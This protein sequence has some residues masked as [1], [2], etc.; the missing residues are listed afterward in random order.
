VRRVEAE[1]P[2]HASKHEENEIK[3][4]MT[5]TWEYDGRIERQVSTDLIIV[6]TGVEHNLS[7]A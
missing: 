3:T 5:K 1:R 7:R 2:E 4:N 6:V